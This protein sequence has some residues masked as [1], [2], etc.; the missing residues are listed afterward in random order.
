MIDDEEEIVR[1]LQGD[2]AR[3]DREI[4]FWPE[5]PSKH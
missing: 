4:R 1:G 3:F 5:V 2:I